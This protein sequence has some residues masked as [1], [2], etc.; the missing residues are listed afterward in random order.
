MKNWD[1][2]ARVAI[3]DLD[4]QRITG[5]ILDANLVSEI[6]ETIDFLRLHAGA[7]EHQMNFMC[8]AMNQ[9][10]IRSH[11]GFSVIHDGKQI[12]FF[13]DLDSDGRIFTISG[14]TA[15]CLQVKDG[16]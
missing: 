8:D 11:K 12:D 6:I 14:D 16:A 2:R 13:G 1:D 4:E 10:R 5:N 15:Y 3:A 9:V 7:L